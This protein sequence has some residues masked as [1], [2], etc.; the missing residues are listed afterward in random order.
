M[1]RR[2]PGSSGDK[3]RERIEQV[4]QAQWKDVG[5]ELTVDNKPIRTILAEIWS[6][7]RHPP[8]FF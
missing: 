3:T 2:N 4:L 7:R 6:F 5:I 8:D 1:I